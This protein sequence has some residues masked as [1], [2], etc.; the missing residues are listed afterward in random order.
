MLYRTRNTAAKKVFTTFKAFCIIN[1]NRYIV[2]LNRFTMVKYN[3]D[4]ITT[5]IIESYD[6]LCNIVYAI[7]LKK[8]ISVQTMADLSLMYATG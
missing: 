1:Y 7:K 3:Y 8:F 2:V 5:R 6:H 4:H